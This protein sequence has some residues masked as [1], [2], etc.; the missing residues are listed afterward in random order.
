MKRCLMFALVAALAG[1]GD[2]RP[3]PLP[4]VVVKTVTVNVP[5]PIPCVKRS[6]VP[7]MPPKIGA[8]LNGDAGHDLN[9]VS[10]SAL[11]LRSALDKALALLGGC[12]IGG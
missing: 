3:V 4:P 2:E 12:L 7:A 8:Q 1:C 9:V 5:V 10:A 6:D 11:R